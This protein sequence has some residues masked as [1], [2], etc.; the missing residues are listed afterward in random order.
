MVPVG[1]I[2][3]EEMVSL[4]STHVRAFLKEADVFLRDYSADHRK[5]LARSHH[6][7]TAEYLL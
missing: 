7:L 5:R 4:M 2:G 3:S 1:G 6:R